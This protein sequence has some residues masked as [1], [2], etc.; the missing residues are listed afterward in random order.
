VSAA[1]PVP[2]A[3]RI[4]F[5]RAAIGAAAAAIVGCVFAFFAG[6]L[7][8]FAELNYKPATEV[9]RG[10]PIKLNPSIVP[11]LWPIH[12]ARLAA[13]HYTPNLKPRTEIEVDLSKIEDTRRLADLNGGQVIEFD[14]LQSGT[15]SITLALFSRTGR[16][17]ART[18]PLM[19]TIKEHHEYSGKWNAS[20][21]GRECT[22]EL[23]SYGEQDDHVYGMCFFED[24]E[25]YPLVGGKFNGAN[26]RGT[27]LVRDAAQPR[28]LFILADTRES[29]GRL[30][31]TGTADLL[32]PG[33][34]DWELVSGTTY[35]FTMSKRLR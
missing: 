1:A 2:E 28:R 21:G 23:H 31:A 18:Q 29:D 34:M 22:M 14:A 16:E 4:T 30:I 15:A 26:F 6:Y 13:Q 9:V 5:K 33:R 17:I 27:M 20:V 24:G 25:P 8:A 19:Y 10:D 7:W 32:K 35:R 3:A 12:H 11:T